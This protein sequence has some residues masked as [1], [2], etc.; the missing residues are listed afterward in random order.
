M[1]KRK[2]LIAIFY[3]LIISAIIAPKEFYHSLEGHEDSIDIIQKGQVSQFSK[4]HQHC[5][6]LN[7][8][9]PVYHFQVKIIL[10]SIPVL[11]TRYFE[12]SYSHYNFDSYSLSLSR[13]PP[14]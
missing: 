8:E 7:F 9:S 12:H 13:A 5:A 11:V 10:L 14:L 4:T 3:L 1:Q 6:I 2:Q